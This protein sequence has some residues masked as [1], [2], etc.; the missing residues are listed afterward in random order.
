MLNKESRDRDSM[1]VK[2]YLY[3]LLTWDTQRAHYT[4]GEHGPNMRILKEWGL[5]FTDCQGLFLEGILREVTQ[6]LQFN[7]SEKMESESAFWHLCFSD[8]A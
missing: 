5:F 6:N 2:R 4:Y 3:E 7:F 1:S 8:S